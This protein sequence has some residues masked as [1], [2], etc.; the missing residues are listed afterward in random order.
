MN[1]KH[2][3]ESEF[4]CN[5]C[6]ETMLNGELMAALELVRHYFN[7]PVTITSSYRCPTHNTNVG[8]AKNSKHLAGI[9]AD[10]QVKNTEPKVVADFLESVFPESYGIGRYSTFTHI[11]VR[12]KKARWG[13]NQ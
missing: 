7:Q 2:F 11:D 3:K 9:A 12:A 5:H 4:A 10:I 13:S 6:G 8:G 1:T